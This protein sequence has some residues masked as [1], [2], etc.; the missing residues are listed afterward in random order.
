MEKTLKLV[1]KKDLIMKF[2]QNAY[3]TMSSEWNA[4]TAAER[5]IHLAEN[6]QNNHF[7]EY[8]SGPCS[9]IEF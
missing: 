6:I 4:Q 8:K 7:N 1:Q 3:M 5:L 9:F 2:G